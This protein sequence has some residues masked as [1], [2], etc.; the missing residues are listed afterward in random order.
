MLVALE[1]AATAVLLL[2]AVQTVSRSDAT[3]FAN[4]RRSVLRLQLKE[5]ELPPS[6]RCTAAPPAAALAETAPLLLGLDLLAVATAAAVAAA[7]LH[8]I[9]APPARF[10]FPVRGRSRQAP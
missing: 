2:E 4:R 1:A 10:A 8:L 7:A 3:A 6:L 5:Q 9:C